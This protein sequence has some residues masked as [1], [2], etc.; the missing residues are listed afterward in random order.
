MR[1][2]RREGAFDAV[3]SLLTSF[4]VF[5]DSSDDRLA[6]D[7]VLADLRPGGADSGYIQRMKGSPDKTDFS[8]GRFV[9]LA[10]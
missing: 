5:E 8:D 6:L 7:N 10:L 9:L 4:G 1:R 3:V 2:F